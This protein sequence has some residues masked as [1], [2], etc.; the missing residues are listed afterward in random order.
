[1]DNARA[2]WP[3]ANEN[4]ASAAFAEYRLEK[5]LYQHKNDFIDD[6]SY[7]DIHSDMQRNK[8]LPP[9]MLSAI[10]TMKLE[11]E[12]IEYLFFLLVHQASSSAF[13]NFILI[14]KD[15]YE[16][17]S[18]RLYQDFHRMESNNATT[19][20]DYHGPIARL[21][22]EIPKHVDFNV[23]RC[24]F[25]STFRRLILISFRPIPPSELL[26]FSSYLFFSKAV[27]IASAIAVARTASIFGGAWQLVF[28]QAMD[29]DGRML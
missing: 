16:W 22:R 13:T 4:A 28:R 11:R 10:K 8:I 24:K 14:L 6:F 27:D 9:E 17:L 20:D 25:V 23:H 1:M 2:R 18:E 12:R 26:L 15:K 19:D 5:I 7:A 3:L 29:C 21:R